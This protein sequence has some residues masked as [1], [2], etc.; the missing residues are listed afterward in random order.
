VKDL[1]NVTK[2][3]VTRMALVRAGVEAVLEAVLMTTTRSTVEQ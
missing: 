2:V 1:K 3:A